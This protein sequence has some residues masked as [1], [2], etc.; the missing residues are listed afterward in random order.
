MV[1]QMDNLIPNHLGRRRY[2]SYLSLVYSLWKVE[3]KAEGGK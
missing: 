1:E 3:L 2:E